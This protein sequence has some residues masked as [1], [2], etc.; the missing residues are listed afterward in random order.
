M[1]NCE[2]SLAL[3][4]NGE[5]AKSGE[6]PHMAAIG[7]K[8]KNRVAHFVCGGSLISDQ[9]VLTAAHC[10]V[11]DGVSSSIVRLGVLNLKVKEQGSYEL[12]IAIDSFISHEFYDPNTKKND[13]AVIKLV[14]QVTLSKFIRPACLM[15]PNNQVDVQKAIVIGFGLTQAFT[16]HTSDILQKAKLRIKDIST[17]RN[18]LDNENIDST[19]I[20]AGDSKF[21]GY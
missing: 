14:N 13:I 9:F 1:E 21:W 18:Y 6:F 10:R 7:Y 15:T 3:I 12:D 4:I 5:N 16:G 19:Q 17:C 2:I 11:L 20:C 8:D